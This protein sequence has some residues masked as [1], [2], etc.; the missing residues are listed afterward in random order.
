MFFGRE[1][2][3]KELRERY[4]SRGA[5]IIAVLGRRRVGKSQ[6]IYESSKDFDGIVIS[7][8]CSDTGYKSNLAN[9]TNEIRDKL[10]NKYLSFDSLHDVLS[11]LYYETAKWSGGERIAG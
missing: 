8:E 3:L 4:A 11:F 1:E 10:N 5:E 6:L 2:E 7:Y 9:L